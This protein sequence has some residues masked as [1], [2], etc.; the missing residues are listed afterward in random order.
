M[1]LL[2]D[3]YDSFT[4]NLYHYLGELGAEIDVFRND[5]ISV[6]EAMALA[7]ARHRHLAWALR[8]GP[9]R[10]QPAPDR[11]RG[12]TACPMLGVCLGHQA[13]AQAFGAVVG[14]PARSC[15]ASAA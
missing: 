3:N 14:G 9:G 7:P 10:H 12:K 8:P 11:G 5:A 1:L 2:I 13:I 4:Y 6:A 15:T